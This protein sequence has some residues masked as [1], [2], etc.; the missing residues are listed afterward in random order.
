[1]LELLVVDAD[2]GVCEALATGLEQLC[3]AAVIRARSGRAATQALATRC[4]DLAIVEP[5]LPDISGFEL[6]ESIADRNIPVL[7][8]NGHPIEQISC[9]F[10]GYP[11]LDKPFRLTAL[12]NAARL[13]LQNVA[14]NVA[15][16]HRSY[17]RLL[18]AREEQHR[19]LSDSRQLRS[20]SSRLK[21]AL[22]RELIRSQEL[23]T[24][25]AIRWHQQS[26][27]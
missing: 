10:H 2:D 9:K 18:T 20:E 12:A 24:S 23:A 19:I 15:I 22:A 6:V 3:G 1:M 21:D 5:R 14:E 16:L 17:K 4:L 8:I 11:H 27:G 26:R 7:L 25:L 13:A